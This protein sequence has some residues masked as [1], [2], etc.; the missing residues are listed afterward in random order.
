MLVVRLSNKRDQHDTPQQRTLA[1][2]AQTVAHKNKATVGV[3]SLDNGHRSHQ[4]E[5][6][7]TRIAEMLK[8]HALR[9][10]LARGGIRVVKMERREEPGKIIGMKLCHIIRAAN[11][12][13]RP[14]DCTH[15]QGGRSLVDFKSA[16][17][18]DTAV[19]NQK[20]GNNNNG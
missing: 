5:Q 11:H 15:Q 3:D 13:Q 1:T 16:L 20:Y 12:I 6:N 10:K 14:A 4:E 2:G 19:T 18:S 8:Q 7:L 9:H 17:K